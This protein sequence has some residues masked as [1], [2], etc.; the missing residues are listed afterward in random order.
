[1]D[2]EITIDA[3]HNVSKYDV[4]LFFTGDSD[5]MP[6]VSYI[7]NSNKKVYIYS[8]KNNVSQELKTGAD[9]YIDVL[10]IDEDIWGK[11]LEV[12]TIL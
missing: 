11:N 12:R 1:M 9:G 4:A 8:S 3:V 7:R 6:L 10:L 5:F 2:V